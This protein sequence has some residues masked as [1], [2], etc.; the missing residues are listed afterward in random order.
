M[1]L[2]SDSDSV[3]EADAILP[4]RRFTGFKDPSFI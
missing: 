2:H 1:Q 4:E 3:K